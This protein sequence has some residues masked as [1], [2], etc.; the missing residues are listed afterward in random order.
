[1]PESAHSRLTRDDARVRKTGA[2][3]PELLAAA[4]EI[5]HGQQSLIEGM[6][7]G[8]LCGG[9]VLIEGVP[10]LAKTLAAKTLA[11]LLDLDFQRIQFTPDLLPADLTG[12]PIYHPPSGEF[13]T[14]KGP[15]FTQVL[16]ADEINRAPAKVQ[17]A[18]LEA[19]EEGQVTLGET[20]HRLPDP[21]FVL[22]TQNPLEQEG[23]YP[24]PE[25]QLDRFFLK[26]HVDYPSRE[27]EQ[28]MVIAHSSGSA[29][30]P[31]LRIGREQLAAAREQVR[32]IHLA[33]ELLD[34]LLDL[35][36]ASREPQRFGADQ[37][38]PLIAHGISPRGSIAL[39]R[40]AKALAFIR[41][42]SY[43]VPDDLYSI[44]H[45][46]LRHRLLLSYEAE[47]DGHT[48]DQI[49]DQLLKTL[50]TP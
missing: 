21:F 40:A 14:R 18:L 48:P 23:T 31:R 47:A 42:R 1:M 20:S 19:M 13:R 25:A 38:A 35:T 28:R 16:L 36:A 2:F 3:I 5:V 9:H 24:L 30:T 7:V 50:P 37:L 8:L 39:A 46:V 49:I 41:G 29:P 6:L 32:E 15:V 45:P 22:A 43:V 27:A 12:T 11:R 44:A 33:P 4:E 34:H 26:L 10:G 17:S